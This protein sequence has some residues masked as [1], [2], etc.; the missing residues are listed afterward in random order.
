[1]NI[2]PS[3]N[4][5][6]FPFPQL[7]IYCTFQ[8]RIMSRLRHPNVVLFLGYVTQPPNLSIL[9]EYLPRFVQVPLF[10]A[11]MLLPPFQNVGR[12]DFSRFIALL[13]TQT[14]IIS[15]CIANTMNLEKSKR[16]TFWNGGSTTFVIVAS[17]YFIFFYS[18]IT[19]HT[20]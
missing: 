6:W 7:G 3:T 10:L 14:N 20:A 9:T 18:F 17:E 13:C 8:V 1:M 4:D 11:K 5:Y 15:K 2:S 16:H 12:F 19:L